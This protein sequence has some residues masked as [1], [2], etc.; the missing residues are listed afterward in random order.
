MIFLMDMRGV[1]YLRVRIHGGTSVR[2]TAVKKYPHLIS[3]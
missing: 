1:S 3:F 2:L